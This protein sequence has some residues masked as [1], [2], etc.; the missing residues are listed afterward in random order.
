MNLKD[1]H[2][3]GHSLGAQVCGFAGQGLDKV[4]RITG[5]D[6]AGPSFDGLPKEARLDKTDAD[7]V[8][9]IHTDSK[10]FIPYFGLGTLQAVG[11]ID[12]YPNGGK[13]QPNCDK[14]RATGTIRGRL[15]NHI[16]AL[17]YFI[18]SI[19]AKNVPLAHKC[20][21]YDTFTRGLCSDCG[22][23][24]EKCAIMGYRADEW[25]QFKDN[26]MENKMFLTTTGNYPYFI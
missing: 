17:E 15:C 2:L 9:V 11:H 13:D 12:F 10:P 5:L 1:V 16:R 23:N 8:D 6:P 26:Q 14:E 3:I 21:N 25:R 20:T 24:S 4:G 18:A 19:N 22:V 7:F